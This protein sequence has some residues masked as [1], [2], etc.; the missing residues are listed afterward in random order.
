[1][2]KDNRAPLAARQEAFIQASPEAVWKPAADIQ[3]LESRA[4]RCADG[5]AG[6]PACR[7]AGLSLESR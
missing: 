3:Y 4:A 5:P 1:M 2:T 6:R 7:R